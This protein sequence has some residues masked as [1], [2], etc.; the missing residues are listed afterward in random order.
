MK[1]EDL[2][3]QMRDEKCPPS[4]VERVR[5]RI[6][7]GQAED[8]EER[9]RASGARGGPL[10]IAAVAGRAAGPTWLR[11]SVVL[12]AVAVC[13]IVGM[14][15]THLL[16]SAAT[17]ESKEAD[18]A[19]VVRETQVAIGYFAEGLLRASAQSEKTILKE[20][21]PPLRDGLETVKN[22]LSKPI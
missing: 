18:R 12:G 17:K 10:G 22:K 21:V 5:E 13:V 15:V 11:A 8:I 4:V 19:R 16:P 7:R 2:I 6:A 9:L 1:L 3:R 20:A 14:M